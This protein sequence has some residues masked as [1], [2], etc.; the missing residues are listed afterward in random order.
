MAGSTILILTCAHIYLC[1]L[2]AAPVLIIGRAHTLSVFYFSLNGG[3]CGELRNLEQDQHPLI[4][5]VCDR[6]YLPVNYTLLNYL[7]E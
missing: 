4:G 3:S 7:A 6:H 2:G 5:Y 1:A